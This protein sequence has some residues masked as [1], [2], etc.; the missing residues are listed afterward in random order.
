M[1]QRELIAHFLNKRMCF[2]YKSWL[3]LVFLNKEEQFKRDE[4]IKDSEF[5]EYKGI[6]WHCEVT[7]SKL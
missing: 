7:Q 3:N 2:I 5:Y 6:K 4:A 1:K